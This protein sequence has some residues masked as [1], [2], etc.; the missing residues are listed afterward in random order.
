MIQTRLVP[1][2]TV[3]LSHSKV[4]T[5]RKG[6]LV[7]SA[8]LPPSTLEHLPELEEALIRFRYQDPIVLGDL[9]AN[10]GQ[11]QNLHS[12]QVAEL[13]IEFGLMD[14]LHHF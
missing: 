9:S 10:I 12:H 11:V 13:L 1:D 2:N 6:T 14:L 4:V 5:D 7:I 8:Y 3:H